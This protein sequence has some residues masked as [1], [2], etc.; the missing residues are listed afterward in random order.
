M[1]LGNFCGHSHAV[2][3]WESHC[4]P[5]RDHPR[6]HRGGDSD[7]GGDGV[8]DVGSFHRARPLHGKSHARAH[9]LESWS[10]SAL[11]SQACRSHHSDCTPADLPR[12]DWEGSL[13][14]RQLR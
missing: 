3:L 7:G 14:N 12:E 8:R 11:S 10:T 2:G 9:N 13:L 6:R 5:N 4:P 1:I